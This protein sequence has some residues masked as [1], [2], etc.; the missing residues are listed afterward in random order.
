MAQVVENLPYK[1]KHEA[2][3]S[4][5]RTIK[6]KE[7]KRKCYYELRCPCPV[8]TKR[9]SWRLQLTVLI[10]HGTISLN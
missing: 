6:R 5:P 4:I 10:Q 8:P 2:L 9:F 7:K 3:T 1:Y